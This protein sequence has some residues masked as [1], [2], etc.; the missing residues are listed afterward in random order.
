MKTTDEPP[1]PPPPPSAT[2]PEPE[3]DTDVPEADADD[4]EADD[5]DGDLGVE[6]QVLSADTTP[7]GVTFLG[8]GFTSLDHYFRSELAELVDPSILWIL[9]TLD[10][11]AVQ[12]RFESGRYRFVW[13]GGCV[14]RVEVPDPGGVE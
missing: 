13:E 14:Y 9:D 11:R 1:N 3:A 12:A 5:I 7:E 10:I 4:P 6:E 2:I 8:D